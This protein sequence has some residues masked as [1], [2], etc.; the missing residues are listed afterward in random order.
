MGI[1]LYRLVYM[2][3]KLVYFLYVILH[4]TACT[5]NEFVTAWN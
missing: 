4:G 3:N 1:L 5:G 2:E